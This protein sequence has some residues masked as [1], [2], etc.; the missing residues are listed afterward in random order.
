MRRLSPILPQHFTPA[1][2]RVFEAVTLGKRAAL[3]GTGGLLNESGAMRGPFNAWLHRPVLGDL[4]QRLGEELRFE[5]MLPER[6]REIAVLVAAA[7]W[8][9]QFEW[10]AH[11]KLARRAGVPDRIIDDIREGRERITGSQAET[12]VHAF[13][14]ALLL[15]AR[16][17]QDTYAHAVAELGD[18]GVVELVILLG[19]Y[20]MVAMTLNVFEVPLPDGETPPFDE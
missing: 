3:H 2:R 14:R 6:L 11:E 4:A 9:S 7:H 12:S 15:T 16:V 8:R 19:Y 18:S 20:S 5:G 13:A 1:Q 10:W 17:P